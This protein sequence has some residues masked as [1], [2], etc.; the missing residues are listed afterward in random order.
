MFQTYE[1]S[2]NKKAAIYAAFFDGQEVLNQNGYFEWCG[3]ELHI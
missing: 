3:G 1:K 2:L